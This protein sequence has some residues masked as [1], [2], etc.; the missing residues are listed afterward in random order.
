MRA[1]FALGLRSRLTPQFCEKIFSEF[2]VSHSSLSS[3]LV[4]DPADLFGDTPFE[5]VVV[6]GIETD[7]VAHAQI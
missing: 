6:D 1:G 3:K 2:V 4:K 7:V 5:V